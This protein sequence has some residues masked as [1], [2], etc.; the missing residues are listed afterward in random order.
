MSQDVIALR[1][2]QLNELQ[3]HLTGMTRALTAQQAEAA[4]IIALFRSQLGYESIAGEWV[5]EHGEVI[6][7]NR[8][9]KIMSVSVNTI[10]K[11]IGEGYIDT[12]PDGRVL[13][14]SLAEWA[15][16]GG[17]QCKRRTRGGVKNF[18]EC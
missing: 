5:R 9:A 4:G 18:K 16:S 6:P 1:A 8:A 14:R 11:Y 10:I 12:A 7:K 13:V 15:N 2:D 17:K 3:Q